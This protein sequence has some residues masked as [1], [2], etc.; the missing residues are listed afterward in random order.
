MEAKWARIWWVRPVRSSTSNREKSRRSSSTRYLV[1]MVLAPSL[2][3]F[4]IYTRFWA[5]FFSKYPVSSPSFC[6]SLPHTTHRYSLRSSRSFTFWFRT[7]RASAFFAA[8]TMP[9]VF[10]SMRLTRAGA[11]DC[12]PSGSY[13]PLS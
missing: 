8:M 2:G 10:R 12:S 11:K 5:S 3:F 4:E 9:P 1:R 13:S 6:S 7:R